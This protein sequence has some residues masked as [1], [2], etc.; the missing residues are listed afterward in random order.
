MRQAVSIQEWRNN[1]NH[2]GQDCPGMKNKACH[3]VCTWP[4]SVMNDTLAPPPVASLATRCNKT[5]CTCSTCETE[6]TKEE[7]E[8][9][10]N[11]IDIVPEL[12]D[13]TVIRAL[14]NPGI[15]LCPKS[16]ATHPT[17]NH[18]DCNKRIATSAKASF[19]CLRFTRPFSRIGVNRLLNFRRR[20][21]S[22]LVT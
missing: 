17:V 12:I 8:R 1:N 3:D 10:T 7:E 20:F 15:V 19:S 5:R 2:M 4:K 16:P 9:W 6:K 18:S 14:N 11:D 22:F 21:C 13:C